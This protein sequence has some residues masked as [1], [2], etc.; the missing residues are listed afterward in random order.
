MDPAS[1]ILLHGLCQSWDRLQQARAQILKDGLVLIE[2]NA[3]GDLKHSQHPAA[4]IERD[5]LASLC[6]CWKLLG[7]DV[8]P[9]EGS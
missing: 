4:Q 7:Y 9:P 6:R 8:A 3:N 5:S 2:K 1:E